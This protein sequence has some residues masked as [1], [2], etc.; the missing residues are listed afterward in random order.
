MLS[1]AR[2]VT[3]ATLVVGTLLWFSATL[4]RLA[5]TY[6]LYQPGTTTLRAAAITQQHD[7]LRLAQNFAV[8]AWISYG[9]VVSATIATV[10]AW[11]QT[12]R[13]EGHLVIVA[14]LVG[15]SLAWQGWILPTELAL[16]REFPSRSVPP[17]VERNGVIGSLVEKRLFRQSPADMLSLLTAATVVIVLVVQP[18]RRLHG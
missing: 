1:T 18:R 5:V 12:L 3:L 15:A 14:L 4:G 13:A 2:R 7:Q 16:A 10:A 17:P 9:I 11:R 8:L 6:D